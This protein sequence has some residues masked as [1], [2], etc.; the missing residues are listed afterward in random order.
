MKVAIVHD[1]LPFMGGAENFLGYLID[2][3]P[4]A[5][6]YTSIYNESEINGKIK[7]ANIITSHL[8]KP[9]KVQNHRK[10]FPLLPTAMEQF[11]LRNFDVVISSSSSIAKSVITGPNTMHICYCHSP[12]RY[13]WDFM[14]NYIGDFSGKG[15]FKNRM[16]GY[17]MTFMRVWDYSSSAR[18]DYFVANSVN[19]AKRI[20]KFYRRDSYVIHSPFRS[21]DFNISSI[22]RDFYLCVS[23]LQEYKR[24]DIAIKACNE[25]KV[26]LVIIG[27]GPERKYLQSIAGPTIKF[28]GRTSDE[29]VEK[30]YAEC[31]AFLFPGE[32]DYGLTPLEAQACGRP[33]I[34]LGKG[35]ALETIIPDKTGVFFYDQTSESIKSA[36]N[37]CNSMSFDKEKVRAHAMEFDEDIFKEKFKRFVN[38]K[39]EEF[40]KNELNGIVVY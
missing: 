16:K 19:V 33:V 15:G 20:K 23:R 36:I 37:K 9:N 5:P 22:D 12:M 31:K 2:I 7:H 24:I 29:V 34:A 39:Y 6:I 18:V 35:G 11:D 8:Q 21:H 1:W 32:E 25:L 27:D 14:H 13:A 30:Y 38:E 4:D 40:K 17:L 3:Y 28:L 10:I 26:P